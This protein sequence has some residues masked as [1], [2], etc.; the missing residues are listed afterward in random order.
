MDICGADSTPMEYFMHSISHL[1]SYMFVC[2]LAGG[3]IFIA[4]GTRDLIQISWYQR[5][6]HSPKSHSLLN[7][8]QAVF[9]ITHKNHKSSHI[10]PFA[11]TPSS[12]RTTGNHCMKAGSRPTVRLHSMH[13]RR[14]M[15][16]SL[17]IARIL[18]RTS[19]WSTTC[20]GPM[21]SWPNGS[22]TGQCVSRR[23]H[24]FVSHSSRPW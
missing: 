13:A 22:R 7:R 2:H 6:I 15:L 3:S 17:R 24:S 12:N 1:Y 8:T 23:H 19:C 11:D 18:T 21:H 9:H 16:G 10:I 14:S 20:V 4:N 5:N